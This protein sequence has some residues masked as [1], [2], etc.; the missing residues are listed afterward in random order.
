MY[1]VYRIP[2]NLIVLVFSTTNQTLLKD[3]DD[4]AGI[5]VVLYPTDQFIELGPGTALSGFMK[6]IDRNAQLLNVADAASLDATA[7]ALA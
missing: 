3:G 6:R 2:D 7:K 5:G 1:L 4:L